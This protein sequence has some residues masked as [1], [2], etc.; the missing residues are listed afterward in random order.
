MSH[1]VSKGLRQRPHYAG[2]TWKRSFISTV[3]STVRTNPS[4]KPSFRKRSSNRGNLKTPVLRF[5][6]N[7]NHLENEAFRKRRRYD[8]H[9][10]SQSKFS[11]CKHKSKVTDDCCVFKFLRRSVD[12]EYLIPFQSE[13]AVFEFLRRTVDGA[14]KEILTWAHIKASQK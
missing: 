3:R 10:I 4:R 9:V 1:R 11:S 7:G 8:N 2:G 13:N 5:H 14:L 6:V 12:G